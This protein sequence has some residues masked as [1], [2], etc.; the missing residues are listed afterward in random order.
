MEAI[1]QL[2]PEHAAELR[3]LGMEFMCRMNYENAAQIASPL[4]R[5]S[6]YLM[7]ARRF[8]FAESPFPRLFRKELKPWLRSV[9]RGF[10]RRESNRVA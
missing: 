5:A 2:E 4:A 7:V 10:L 8:E 3:S 1:C 6:A 9:R